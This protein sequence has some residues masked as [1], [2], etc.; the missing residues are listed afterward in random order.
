ME[1]LKFVDSVAFRQS[2]A[3]LQ[4]PPVANKRGSVVWLEAE[5]TIAPDYSGD[6]RDPSVPLIWPDSHWRAAGIDK[7]WWL[8]AAPPA[9]TKL[10]RSDRPYRIRSK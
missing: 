5:A 2:A 3:K 7:A 4:I 1:Y 6:K 8:I 9:M 10:P